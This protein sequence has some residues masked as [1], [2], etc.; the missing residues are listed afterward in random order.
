MELFYKGLFLS[1]FWLFWSN[2]EVSAQQQSFEASYVSKFKRFAKEEPFQGEKKS[3]WE[4]SAWKGER[5]NTQIAVWSNAD[6]NTLSVST[7]S[8][9]GLRNSSTGNHI[10]YN[11]LT[12]FSGVY[13]LGDQKSASCGA[14]PEHDQ[15]AW[16]AD[17][18]DSVLATSLKSNDPMKLW[19][20]IDVPGNTPAGIYEGSIVISSS[21]NSLNLPIRINVLNKTLPPP[22]Q[23]GFH[24]DLWQ[25]PYQLLKL[26][27]D[28]N[29]QQAIAAW[30]DAHFEMLR[31]FYSY[32]ADMGQ[33]AISAHIK[34]QALGGPSM[35]RWTKN[36][37]NSWSYDYTNFERFVNFMVSLGIQKQ[38][39]CFSLIGWNEHEIP[40]YDEASGTIKKLDAP[41]SSTVYNERWNHFLTAFKTYLEGK[42]W[43]DKTIL[44]MDEVSETKM[45]QVV[46]LIQNNSP[47]W[48]IGLTHVKQVSTELKSKIYDVSG[49]LVA[50]ANDGLANK[51][52]TFYTSCSE[53]FPN[54]YVTLEAKPAEMAWMGWYAAQ[55]NFDGYLR[56]AFDFWKSSDPFDETYG[57]NTAGDFSMVYRASNSNPNRLIRSI[58]SELLREGIQDFEKIKILKRDFSTTSAQRLEVLQ[59]WLKRFDKNSGYGAEFL[60][61]KGQN[62]LNNLVSTEYV[63]YCDAYGSN[64]GN[65][66][67]SYIEAKNAINEN[68]KLYTAAYPEKGF[69]RYTTQFIEEKPGGEFTF[70]IENSGSCANTYVWIDWN[71]NKTF[72]ANERVTAFENGCQNPSNLT[73][74]VQI[75]SDVVPGIKRVRIRTIHEAQTPSSC[76]VI[77]DSGT[78]D[79]DLKINDG[80]CTSLSN[81]NTSNFFVEKLTTST[82]SYNIDYTNTVAPLKAYSHHTNTIA[83]AG[84]SETFF[85]DFSLSESSNCARPKVWI[86]W[87]QDG[88]FTD[89]SEEV[90][91]AGI[92]QSCLNQYDYQAA[93]TVPSNAQSGLTRMRVMVK[94]A[95]LEASPCD[96]D[97][98][99]ATHD[100]DLRVTGSSSGSCSPVIISP[101]EGSRLSETQLFEWNANNLSLD[102]FE[103]VISSVP[104]GLTAP[105]IHHQSSISETITQKTITQNLPQD[106]RD[107]S[108]SLLSIKS[109]NV[110][111]ETK[112]NVKAF[113]KY[114]TPKGGKHKIY[115]L[116]ELSTVGGE[117]N[118]N[119]GVTDY[120][121][122]GY[123][124]VTDSRVIAKQGDVITFNFK[125]SG[126]SNCS[127]SKLFIDWN[128]D[129]VF[130]SSSELAYQIGSAQSCNNPVSGNFQI[131]IPSDA[132]E[133]IARMRLMIGD[134]WKSLNPCASIDHLSAI[135]FDLEIKSSYCQPT[136]NPQYEYITKIE[137]GS[138]SHESSQSVNGFEDFSDQTITLT[139]GVDYSFNTHFEMVGGTWSEALSVWV[140]LN[141]NST[142]ED[143]ERLFYQSPTKQSNKV[144]ENTFRIPE[145]AATGKKRIRFLLHFGTAT[146]LPCK[147]PGF[148]EYEDYTLVIEE[149]QNPVIDYCDAKGSSVLYEFIDAVE[150]NGT[151]YSSGSNDGYADFTSTIIPVENTMSLK[152]IP[153]FTGGSYIEN[154]FVWV[155]YNQNGSF[156]DDNELIFKT[157]GN[158]SVETV[159]TIPDDAMS[160][161]TRMRIVMKYGSTKAGSCEYFIYGEVEDYTLNIGANTSKRS[162]N[163]KQLNIN[164]GSEE[165][166]QFSDTPLFYP[167]HVVTDGFLRFS[168]NINIGEVKNSLHLFNATG[169]LM[170]KPTI[171]LL[172]PKEFK[173]SFSPYPSGFYILRVSHQGVPYQIRIIKRE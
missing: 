108:V 92:Y 68:L 62:I 82:C 75:P 115:F 81:Y 29:P 127:Y 170:Q 100:F 97:Q 49:G 39:N 168:R 118:I 163:H 67:S 124:H 106:G 54:N 135:D 129:Y 89:S 107:L 84:L 37:N 44:Y 136:S 117:A 144:F 103:L 113:D 64:T 150:I 159:T 78:I 33:K 130:D 83:E 143:D 60:V 104:Y 109:Q 167:N 19:I 158:S 70:Y 73:F 30:S 52:R 61:K 11:K 66:Y 20:S 125:N 13:I 23:W 27:N 22:S 40:Y 1:I 71:D 120:P 80:Y 93:I 146:A 141:E 156:E 7:G 3:R 102:E 56:W 36:T 17:G 63:G 91:T 41:I 16:I 171:V 10:P 57:G 69:V 153:G 148:G 48:K 169:A 96:I 166:P 140:D 35:I 2:W 14:Y 121:K 133:G 55:N 6:I 105:V 76:G 46:N 116:K 126:A 134:A 131:T 21:A 101:L 162:L 149:N 111:H 145:D 160:G 43:F 132:K 28:A 119:F 94:D 47:S 31:P 50:A 58:R 123:S 85:L 98:N 173:I 51:V 172:N 164:Q 152:L 139:K 4:Q 122:N 26:H 8:G 114:C 53:I 32:L 59:T 45:T 25:Y 90:Y 38:I 142:F 65:H 87:N 34:E 137:L 128:G 5:I 79:L 112:I 147:S 77:V 99:F 86:D 18:L 151:S 72:E 155:D 165:K 110:V 15:T 138:F 9:N 42:G 88:D 24:L 12:I 157:F 154:W 95:W 74:N 161:H